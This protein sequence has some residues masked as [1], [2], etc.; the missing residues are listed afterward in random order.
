MCDI[1]GARRGKP[2][3][4]RMIDK[5][6]KHFSSRGERCNQCLHEKKKKRV[7]L[8]N[9]NNLKLLNKRNKL[10]LGWSHRKI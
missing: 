5:Y 2:F 9:I 10:M 6:I 8:K 7:I 4:D 3:I 1:A